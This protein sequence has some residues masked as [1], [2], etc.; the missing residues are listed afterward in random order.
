MRQRAGELRN[1]ALEHRRSAAV[2]LILDGLHDRW[3]VM[4]GIV[5]TIA[6]EKNRL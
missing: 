6:G 2:E 1:M 4:P 3:V 5:Y